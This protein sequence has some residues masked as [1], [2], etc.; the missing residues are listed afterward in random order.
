MSNDKRYRLKKGVE[1]FEMVDGPLA[2]RKYEK[3]KGYLAIP[4]E[5]KNRFEL[6]AKPKPAAKKAATKTKE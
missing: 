2:G 5:L 6:I 4:D 3:G 1:A